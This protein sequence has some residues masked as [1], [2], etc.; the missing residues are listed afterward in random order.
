MTKQ[1]TIK[2]ATSLSGVGLHTGKV[3]TLT[4]NPAPENHGHKFQRVD[5]SGQPIVN[6]DVSRV[7]STT[8][9]TTIKSDE[10]QVST[11]EHVL[12]AL[13]GLGIDNILMTIDGP[14]VP[15]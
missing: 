4:F 2:K 3:V 5:L 13:V 1:R 10:A 8:R 7:I 11:I 9:G 14:E 15:I 12:S 6:A